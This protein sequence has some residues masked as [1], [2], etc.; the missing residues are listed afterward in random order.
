MSVTKLYKEFELIIAYRFKDKKNLSNSLI[1][2]S[3]YKV[4]KD[5]SINNI[6]EFERLEFLGDRVLG[7]TIA[8]LIYNKFQKLNEGDL[9]K[10]F[11]FLVQGEFLYKI[12]LNLNLD[13]FIK[14]NKQK[15]NYRY[16][17]SILSDSLESLIGAIY[18]D[19]GLKE[20]TNFIKLFWTPYLDLTKTIETDSKTKLQEISQK[21]FKVLPKYTLLTKKGPPHS[22]TFTVSLKALD[23]KL[24]KT[25]AK[26]IQEAEKKAAKIILDSINE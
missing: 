6:Y 2:P 22:P 24:I 7:L 25:S 19:G 15:T 5:R 17:K 20:A 26:S 9:T 13:T 21:K 4:K 10:K 1:H 11:S 8:S 12:A 23:L 18:V 3:S 16:N 14:Y